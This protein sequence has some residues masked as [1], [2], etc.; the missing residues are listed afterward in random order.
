VNP[1]DFSHKGISPRD[2]PTKDVEMEIIPVKQD[3]KKYVD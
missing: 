1:I 2:E 3:L